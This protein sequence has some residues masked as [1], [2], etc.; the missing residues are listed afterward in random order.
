MAQ[1]GIHKISI[2]EGNDKVAPPPLP[3]TTPSTTTASIFEESIKSPTGVKNQQESTFS[4]GGDNTRKNF[5]L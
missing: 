5:Y 4:V 3:L 2:E 1:N